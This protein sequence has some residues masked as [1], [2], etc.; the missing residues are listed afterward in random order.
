MK[1]R[2]NIIN[3]RRAVAGIKADRDRIFVQENG[4]PVILG[5]VPREVYPGSVIE[6]IGRGFSS[7]RKNIR[8]AIGD[9]KAW[10]LEA[11]DERLKVLTDIRSHGELTLE[12]G[13]KSASFNGFILPG[14][15]ISNHIPEK[16]IRPIDPG[17]L[18]IYKKHLPSKGTIKILTVFLT[19]GDIVPAAT[20]DDANNN[21][22]GKWIDATSQTTPN[23]SNYYRQVS[24]D[25]LDVQVEPVWDDSS[26][27]PQWIKL[28][29]IASEYVTDERQYNQKT[30][31]WECVGDA[32]NV[33][34]TVLP[35]LWAEAAK[36]AEDYL[37]RKY[38]SD[39]SLNDYDVLACVLNL[40]RNT[41]HSAP[42]DPWNDEVVPIR[43]W[44][45]MFDSSFSYR[46]TNED[47]SISLDH[48]LGLLV[49][50]DM[51][52]WGRC[53]HEIGHLLVTSPWPSS[54]IFQE[55]LYDT[56]L[57]E[58]GFASAAEFDLMGAQ[59]EGP[60]F[61]GYNIEQLGYYDAGN[62]LEISWPGNNNPVKAELV[63]HGLEQNTDPR[64]NHMLKIKVN[65]SLC[66][67][68]EVRQRSSS[69]YGT[70][71]A[72]AYTSDQIFDQC[73]PLSPVNNPFWGGIVVTK[74]FTGGMFNNQETRFITLLFD[75][76]KHPGYSGPC[77]LN[78]DSTGKGECTEDE[79]RLIK[80]EVESCDGLYPMSCTVNVSWSSLPSADPAGKANLY[81]ESIGG[82]QS[83]DIWV[84]RAPYGHYDQSVDPEGRPY[85]NGD[86]PM[87]WEKNYLCGRVHNTG[88][89]DIT[90]DITVTFTG[91]CP[92]SVGDN[93]QWPDYGS[94]ILKG[95][96]AGGYKDIL[97]TNDDDGVAVEWVPATTGHTCIRMWAQ[98][99]SGE[100]NVND[101][102]A[103]ENIFEIDAPAASIPDP[104]TFPLQVQNP[105][106]EEAIV[107]LTISGVPHGYIAQLPYSRVKL[108]PKGSQTMDLTVVPTLDY[109]KYSDI[110]LADIDITGYVARSYRETSGNGVLRPSMMIPI[111]GVTAKVRPKRKINS[112]TICQSAN[113]TESHLVRIE[114][115][116][117]P[118]LSEV[119]L[120]IDLVRESHLIWYC[121]TY[122]GGSG[123]FKAAI[124]LKE[125]PF[126]MATPLEESMGQNDCRVQAHIIRDQR[127]APADS[128]VIYVKKFPFGSAPE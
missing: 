128:N 34:K 73:I 10:V 114:G 40:N 37:Q 113:N 28:F 125:K 32:P 70:D 76:L 18:Y 112:I 6:I 116:I 29:G 115:S 88:T 105:L 14:P 53:A 90:E 109:P 84:D 31:E 74:V 15:D 42:G 38:G 17:K 122:T 3:G 124:D 46:D 49:V 65:D 62:I 13:G 99:V 102:R 60:L 24:Y 71:A 104:I 56:D 36:A 86:R 8:V 43:G 54:S 123:Q 98:P 47:I 107:F 68:V 82:W 97:E 63:A 87:E 67:Y 108:P 94:T 59:D 126:N 103:Q 44:G 85:G 35:R 111:G 57:T 58:P 22:I 26:G 110:P 117:D 79:M 75:P 101:N 93:G 50:D 69:G 55:D 83:P 61:S 7:D 9:Y 41:I 80:I 48:D 127:A 45:N 39:S 33:I 12:V 78:F 89:E 118:Q 81:V 11:S 30:G 119:K 4:S 96:A 91:A 72:N 77:T 95:I 20:P 23:V 121:E 51:A 100:Y 1:K 92:P 25:Q 52:K 16:Y 21:Q 64:K 106:D 5:V 19:P 27:K 120:R 66:Y 2:G